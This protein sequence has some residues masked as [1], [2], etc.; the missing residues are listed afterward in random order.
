MA[1]GPKRHRP[2]AACALRVATRTGTTAS[3][4]CIDEDRRFRR[5]GVEPPIGIEPMTYSLRVRATDVPH[6]PPE[7]VLAGQRLAGTTADI[8]E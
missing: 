7:S 6:Y 4:G 5:S 2:D 1:V 8:A 3:R